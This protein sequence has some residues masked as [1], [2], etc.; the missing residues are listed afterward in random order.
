MAVA[1]RGLRTPLSSVC[2]SPTILQPN[3]IEDDQGPLEVQR[4]NSDAG[5][6]EG[7]GSNSRRIGPTRDTWLGQRS[8][9]EV[10]VQAAHTL[11]GSRGERSTP[12]GRGGHIT[13][14]EQHH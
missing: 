10:P 5:G 8:E 9:E 3:F 1:L 13:P 2:K 14:L 4:R 7:S 6:L 12:G 11:G